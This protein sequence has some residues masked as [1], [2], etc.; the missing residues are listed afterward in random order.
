MTAAPSNDRLSIGLRVGLFVLLGWL[1][2]MVFPL[3]MLPL[4]G[5]LVT[6]AL[7][8]F[9]AG[10]VANA[11]LVRIFERGSLEDLGLV[12]NRDSARELS[13]GAA[14]GVGAGGLLLGVPL[15]MGWAKFTPA[16]AADHPWA[17]FAFV[18]ITLLFG[19]VGE[20][21]L[22]RGYAFQLLFR[23]IGPFATTL[24][25]GVLFGLVH[26]GNANSTLLGV[27]N[28]IAW[29]ILLGYAYGRTRALWLPIG[30]H[31]GW[32]FTLPLFGVNLSGFTMGVTGYAL[33]FRTGE[34]WSGG[35]Y[36]PE[37][38]LPTTVLVIALFWVVRRMVKGSEEARD[39]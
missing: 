1:G 2:M 16:P 11:V 10:A 3:L 7:S 5:L 32:N 4:A 20:E 21:I 18:S 28:T 31:F 14:I 27:F 33:Q 23:T 8:T 6:S 39:A 29:G 38:G 15:A 34:L 37:G 36:G 9:A 26:L 13:A 22:F 19:A 25:A 24:P 30:L 17:A 35:S 12:W